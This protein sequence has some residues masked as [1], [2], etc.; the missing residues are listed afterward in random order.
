MI[1]LICHL[2]SYVI[3]KNVDIISSK[4]A[5]FFAHIVIGLTEQSSHNTDVASTQKYSSVT[6][7]KYVNGDIKNNS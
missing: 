1:T 4:W 3:N 2:S 5:T 6:S 7:F